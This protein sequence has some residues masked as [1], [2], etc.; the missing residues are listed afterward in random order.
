MF[1]RLSKPSKSNTFFLFGARGTGKST[2]LTTQP[3]FKKALVFDLL[4]PTEEDR[5]AR[6]PKLLETL[7]LAQKPSWV[8][9]DEVQRV[10]RLLNLVHRLIENHGVRFALTGSSASK[11]KRGGANLL[12]GRAFVYHLFPLTHQELGADFS[13]EATLAWGTLPK[14][15]SLQDVADKQAYLR[16]YALT[17]LKEEI[18]AEQLVR[19]LDPF[20]LFLE[21]AAQM[22][23]KLL[24][25]SKI[26]NDIGVDA[27]TVQTYFQILEETWLGF[28]LPSYS[29]SI[30]KAQKTHPKFYLF[31]PGVKRALEGDLDGSLKPRS[32]E[33]GEAFE[34]WVILEFFRRNEYLSRG[35]RFSHLRTK[36][37]AE[38]D[39]ILSRGKNP[40]TL[41]EIKSRDRIDEKEVR[42][43]SRFLPSFPGSMAYYLSRD[44]DQRVIDGIRCLFWMR[45]LEEILPIAT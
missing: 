32:S 4:D 29:R 34:H 44:P 43:L 28:H 38:I 31:D 41:V 36:D 15:F 24:N 42:K 45:G 37:D 13:L 35:Y 14:I 6:N 33:F 23:G 1:L 2:L 10:P 26:G 12:A 22:N 21:V 8:V 39:L 19:R 9:I 18:Q 5:L 7:I 3:W 25:W 30:R 27:K 16:S 17:Y 11:L 20:R 40:P